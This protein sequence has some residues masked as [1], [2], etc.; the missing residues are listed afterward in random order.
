V[1]IEGLDQVSEK[2]LA[3]G[4]VTAQNAP[5][6][7][8]SHCSTPGLLIIAC[9]SDPFVPLAAAIVTAAFGNY[10]LA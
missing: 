1:C 2:R 3:M 9:N 5:S 4:R 7:L 6:N 10:S 8:M